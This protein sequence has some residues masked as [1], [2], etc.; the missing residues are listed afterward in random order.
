MVQGQ[1][2]PKVKVK[3]PLYKLKEHILKKLMV[4]LLY[5]KFRVT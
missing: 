1:M 3:V 4:K 5:Q 2:L